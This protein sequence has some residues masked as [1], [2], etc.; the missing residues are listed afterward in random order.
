MLVDPDFVRDTDPVLAIIASGNGDKETT[1]R[2]R[3]GIY[4]IGHFSFDTLISQRG[5]N[6]HGEDDWKSYP[7]FDFETSKLSSYGVCDSIEQFLEDFLHEL[8]SSDR[9]FCISFTCVSKKDQSPE[10]GWRWCKWGPYLGRGKPT[11]KYLYDEPDFDE[12]YCFQ[13]FERVLG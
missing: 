1:Y 12:V 9:K 11:T 4:R 6:L 2:L 7:E 8:D 3:P 10:G 13:I 5:G